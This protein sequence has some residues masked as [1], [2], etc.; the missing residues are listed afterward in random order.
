MDKTKPNRGVPCFQ[1]PTLMAE[2]QSFA[3]F[4]SL[5]TPSTLCNQPS[6]YQVIS[7][8]HVTIMCCDAAVVRARFMITKSW[9]QRLAIIQYFQV[10][11]F[12]MYMCLW[13][14]PVS[15]GGDDVRLE[16]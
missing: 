7:Y 4:Q 11:K 8:I 3:D 12:F 13:D 15:C 10:Y 1:W 9:V 6:V 14:Q 5:P 16:R 2:H